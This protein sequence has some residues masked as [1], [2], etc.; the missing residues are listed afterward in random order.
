ME[1]RTVRVAATGQIIKKKNNKENLM[2]SVGYI[3][4][5][6]NALNLLH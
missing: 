6:C 1:M 4:L 5:E 3:L 2:K